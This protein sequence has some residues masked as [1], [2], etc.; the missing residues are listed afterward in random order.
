MKVITISHFKSKCIGLLK[1][2][3]KTKEPIVLTLRGEPIRTRG[4]QS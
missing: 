4:A 3:Q 2:A 1:S